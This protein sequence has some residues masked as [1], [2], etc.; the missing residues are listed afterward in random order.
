MTWFARPVSREVLM[1]FLS[2]TY[3]AAASAGQWDR[4]AGQAAPR[5]LSLDLVGRASPQPA[6]AYQA[7]A[8][9]EERAQGRADDRRCMRCGRIE[10]CREQR[11]L[12]D[13]LA[14]DPAEQR[15]ACPD[16]DGKTVEQRHDESGARHDQGK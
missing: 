13:D 7:H 6:P 4:A 8:N 14:G 9:D 1:E 16:H 12:G 2:T 15:R 5:V 10:G 11:V 3:D